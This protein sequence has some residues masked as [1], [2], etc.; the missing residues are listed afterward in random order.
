MLRVA[1]LCFDRCLMPKDAAVGID[2]PSMEGQLC[3]NGIDT[4]FSFHIKIG[5]RQSRST[6]HHRGIIGDRPDLS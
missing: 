5:T 4:P 3:R 1:S 2:A 6:I